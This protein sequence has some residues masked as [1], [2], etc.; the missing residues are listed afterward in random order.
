MSA[1]LRKQNG[2]ITYENRN[3]HQRRCLHCVCIFRTHH[4]NCVGKN[5]K[6]AFRKRRGDLRFYSTFF[7]LSRSAY[8][9]NWFSLNEHVVWFKACGMLHGY[10]IKAQSYFAASKRSPWFICATRICRFQIW[11]W[12][13]PSFFLR[14]VKRWNTLADPSVDEFSRLFNR[15]G[16]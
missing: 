14:A 13:K 1:N 10:L 11:S 15:Q 2:W 5:V 9:F 7:T 12:Y 3:F 8:F 16:W 4:I 6:K